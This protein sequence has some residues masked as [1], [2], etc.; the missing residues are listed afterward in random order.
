[1]G[2][3]VTEAMS[4]LSSAQDLARGLQAD[5]IALAAWAEAVDVELDQVEATPQTHRDVQAEICFVKVF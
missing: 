1:M 4:S 2:L 3:Q 5:V